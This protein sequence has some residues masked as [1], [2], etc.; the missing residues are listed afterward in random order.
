MFKV[1]ATFLPPPQP[2]RSLGFFL[3]LNE[4]VYD[5]CMYFDLNHQMWFEWC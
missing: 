4:F 2:N 1:E 3:S 5:Y